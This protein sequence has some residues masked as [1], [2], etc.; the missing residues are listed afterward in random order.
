MT[1]STC[2]RKSQ[3]ADGLATY[4]KDLNLNENDEIEVI[5]LSL[6]NI[7]LLD[8]LR[9]LK[10]PT[11]SG[12]KL[13]P[14]VT[15]Q[16][17]LDYW[18]TES[19]PTITSRPANLKLTDKPH[20]Q[21][22]LDFVDTVRIT[23]PRN[24]SFYENIWSITNETVKVLYCKFLNENPGVKISYGTFLALK[25]FYVRPAATKDLEMCC[26]KNIYMLGW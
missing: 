23:Q 26:C 16:A 24:V 14:L 3:L 17:I 1:S 13:T 10:K 22:S 15:R 5:I 6:K 4:I 19:T 8:K 25:P 11:K 21:T 12:R 7:G 2:K 9:F 20:I 18:H